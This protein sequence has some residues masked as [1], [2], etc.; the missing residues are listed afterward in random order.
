MDKI[1][2]TAEIY[3]HAQP[4]LREVLSRITTIR[5]NLLKQDNAPPRV[6]TLELGFLERLSGK[7]IPISLSL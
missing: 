5:Q 3:V 4:H 7:S 1:T 2:A 6:A